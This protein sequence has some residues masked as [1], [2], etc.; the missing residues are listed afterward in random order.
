M[1]ICDKCFSDIVNNRC[2]CGVWYD[3]CPIEWQPFK[4]VLDLFEENVLPHG[5]ITSFE[6]VESGIY[7]ILFK[8]DFDQCERAKEFIEGL[9]KKARG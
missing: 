7:C 1:K 2:S 6:K 5:N 9:I 4:D 8:G 3:E